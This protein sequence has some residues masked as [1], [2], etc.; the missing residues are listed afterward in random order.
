MLGAIRRT[1]QT[2]ERLEKEQE[3]WRAI[4]SVPDLQCAW[5]LLLSVCRAAVPPFLENHATHRIFFLGTEEMETQ[6]KPKGA[7]VHARMSSSLGEE[8][9]QVGRRTIGAGKRGGRKGDPEK[10]RKP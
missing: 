4:P 6:S 7:P 9:G 10:Q 5:H 2:E 3:L 8:V 1:A